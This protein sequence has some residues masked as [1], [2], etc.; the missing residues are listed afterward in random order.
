MVLLVMQVGK[1]GYGN[2][3]KI[4]HGEGVETTYAHCSVITVKKGEVVKKGDKNRRSR[5]YWE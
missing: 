4:D 5:K 3:I 2:V 1:S